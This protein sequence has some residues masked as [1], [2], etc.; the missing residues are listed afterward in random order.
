MVGISTALP[1]R[2]PKPLTSRLPAPDASVIGNTVVE[3]RPP[4]G[5]SATNTRHSA[6]PVPAKLSVSVP[7]EEPARNSTKFA[8]SPHGA[9]FASL[10]V[11]G[12][13]W[14][15]TGYVLYVA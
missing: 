3:P 4:T 2:V 6:P 15:D 9:R 1:Q 12:G 14:T 11:L 10:L 8:P 5:V 13:T 7:L